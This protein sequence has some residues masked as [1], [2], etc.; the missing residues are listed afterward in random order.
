[1]LKI[2]AGLI[3]PTGGRVVLTGTD[4]TRWDAA[5]RARAGL[6]MK[7]QVPRVFLDIDVRD[8]IELAI[9][10]GRLRGSGSAGIEAAQE[11]AEGVY[12]FGAGP[13]TK[14]REL[15]HGQRQWLEIAMTL[16]TEPTFLLL[17]EP[18]AGM[19]AKERK[20]TAAVIARTPCAVLLVEHDLPF[21]ADLCS[22]LTLLHQGRVQGHGPPGE[23]LTSSALRGVFT[24][25]RDA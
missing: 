14:G 8:N 11:V 19:S 15:A 6:S 2:L 25:P 10:M 4:I 18:T 5:R 22:V 13:R 23:V 3:R 9:R 7:F 21:V 24:R 17:D 12:A 1:M 16:A 20:Q